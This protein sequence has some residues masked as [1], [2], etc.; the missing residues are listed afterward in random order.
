M[1]PGKDDEKA[2]KDEHEKMRRDVEALRLAVKKQGW[3][4]DYLD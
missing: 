3:N 1:E 2:G 4:V